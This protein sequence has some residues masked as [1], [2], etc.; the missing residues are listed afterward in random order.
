MFWGKVYLGPLD[1]AQ[2]FVDVIYCRIFDENRELRPSDISV[3]K[4]GVGDLPACI[5]TS[6]WVDD[7]VGKI[8]VREPTD[9]YVGKLSDR[10]AFN[11]KTPED[12]RV[13]DI[14]V[15]ATN[16]SSA[17]LQFALSQYPKVPMFRMKAT[18][19]FAFIRLPVAELFRFLFCHHTRITRELFHG[20]LEKYGFAE[21]LEDGALVCSHYLLDD[22][23]AYV[24]ALADLPS[25]FRDFAKAG[26]LSNPNRNTENPDG[27][28]IRARPNWFKPLKLSA[29]GSLVSH[30]VPVPKQH[31]QASNGSPVEDS[32]ASDIKTSFVVQ[33]I[34]TI[35]WIP[36][37]APIDVVRITDPEK[38]RLLPPNDKGGVEGGYVAASESGEPIDSSQGSQNERSP[39]RA[40]VESDGPP[41][42]PINRIPDEDFRKGKRY[43]AHRTKVEAKVLT[44]AGT[45]GARG[46]AGSIHVRRVRDSDGEAGVPA[47]EELWRSAVD[48]ATRRGY[49]IES[50]VWGDQANGKVEHNGQA[51]NLTFLPRQD[52]E[53]KGSTIKW[54]M[55]DA[56]PKPIGRRALVFRVLNRDCW[57]YFVD[58]EQFTSRSFRFL[59]LRSLISAG[60]G[61]ISDEAGKE[62]L[63]MCAKCEG[64]WKKLRPHFINAG[65]RAGTFN[66]KNGTLNVQRIMDVIDQLRRNM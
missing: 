57:S 58:I 23:E 36:G 39:A 42:P 17:R 34:T 16:Q 31:Q 33:R 45:A 44:T 2:H 11:I 9:L 53:S 14:E 40:D 59:G 3:V 7:Y 64:A 30:T 41:L 1:R 66:H 55:R 26:F 19:P 27:G 29:M 52:S 13:F 60:N 56:K 25:E 61:E 18:E 49:K 6:I 21:L 8:A 35:D 37:F 5:P 51:A 38:I 62:I 47:F 65:L 12:A 63:L 46:Q 50:V 32:P 4:H 10:Q 48:A 54:S 20:D 28:F 24:I 22:Y 15:V 43:Q